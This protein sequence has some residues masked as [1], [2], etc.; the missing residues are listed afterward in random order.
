LQG[1]MDCPLNNI[2][3]SRFSLRHVLFIQT[4]LIRPLSLVVI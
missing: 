4:L 3:Y 2:F 1:L